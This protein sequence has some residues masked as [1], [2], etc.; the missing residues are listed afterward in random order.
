ML[1]NDELLRIAAM[2]ALPHVLVQYLERAAL[3]LG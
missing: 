1:V 3:E 2:Y